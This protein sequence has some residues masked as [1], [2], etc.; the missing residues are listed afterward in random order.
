MVTPTPRGEVVSIVTDRLARPTARSALIE[1]PP[2]T[3]LPDVVEEVARTLR[4]RALGPGRRVAIAE[5]TGD[6][7]ASERELVEGI[8]ALWCRDC[9]ELREIWSATSASHSLSNHLVEFGR[10][11]LGRGI[12]LVALISRFEK[13]Y[14]CMSSHLLAA[15]DKLED[16]GATAYAIVSPLQYLELYRRRA[17]EDIGFTSLFGRNHVRLT[18]GVL[19]EDE[20]SRQWSEQYGLPDVGAHPVSRGYF[21]IAFRETGGLAA[22]LRLA[23]GEVPDPLPVS[24][25]ARQY[26][27]RVR[28]ALP[29]LFARLIRHDRWLPGD[30]M[31]GAL[32]RIA[33]GASVASD[34]ATV[35]QHPW[36]HV[37]IGPGGEPRCAAVQSAALSL[38]RTP[39]TGPAADFETAY[40]AGEFRRCVDAM[41]AAPGL[42]AALAAAVR[43]CDEAFRF[44]RRSLYLPATA[45]GP[46]RE[47]ATAGIAACVSEDAMREFRRWVELADAHLARD[48]SLEERIIVVGTRLVAVQGDPDPVSACHV[49]IPLLEEVLRLYLTGVLEKPGSGEAFEGVGD[50][51]IRDWWPRGDTTFRRPERG[52]PL[53]A[54]ELAV[55][56]GIWSSARGRPLFDDA[57]DLQ[58]ALSVQEGVRNVVSHQVSSPTSRERE[59]LVAAAAA[60]LDRLCAHAGSSVSS[61]AIKR[62]LVPPMAFLDKG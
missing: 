33:N 32:S 37:L 5:V 59:R 14:L 19:D 49:G 16:I 58:A 2:G 35:A 29:D 18:L 46:I 38:S 31:A 48:P 62:W 25:E 54:T 9:P 27:D 3:N 28:V 56:C 50:E 17:A 22:G 42:P 55:A 41:V 51:Q 45:W 12:R 21:K 10:A 52:R 40:R 8:A 60:R 26:V 11:A 44:G 47:H 30:E 61:D 36:A 4:G 24:V 23:A 57:R 20:A 13:V 43:L 15:L 53:A 39:R 6:L 34:S 1:A 7:F